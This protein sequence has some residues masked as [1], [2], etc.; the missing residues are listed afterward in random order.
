MPTKIEE[1]KSLEHLNSKIYKSINALREDIKSTQEK[2]SKSKG[3]SI[4]DLLD[5]IKRQSGMIDILQ[6]KLD[7]NDFK[8]V[9]L[10]RTGRSIKNQK[11]DYLKKK[12]L[13]RKYRSKF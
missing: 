11:Q 4:M 5:I 13:E 2:A 6:K 12:E 7:D 8:I 10:S 9:D 3:K 1:I